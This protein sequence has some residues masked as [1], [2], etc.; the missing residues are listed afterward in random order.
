MSGP[1]VV[2]KT[3][4]I[5][6]RLVH[7]TTKWTTSVC[8]GS[9]ILGA[10]GLLDGVSATCHWAAIDR[11]KEWGAYPKNDRVVEDG[12]IIIAAGVS[13]GIDI[14][15]VLAAKISGQQFAQAMQL[16]LEYDPKPPFD[17]GSPFKAPSSI[18]EPL[19]ARMIAAFEK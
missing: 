14:A 16:S 7:S 6:V 2:H 15:L 17:V 12:K 18:C 8:T 10:A 4:F 19:R 13:A 5:W 1:L 3:K 11:L 9:L